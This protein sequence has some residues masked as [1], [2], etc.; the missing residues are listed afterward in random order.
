MKTTVGNF[1]LQ[2]DQRFPLDCEL[3][4]GLQNN[5]FLVSLIGNIA[6]DKAILYGCTPSGSK[7]DPGYVFLRTQD[8]PE[9]EVLYFEG[10]S[11][12]TGMYLKKEAQSV[13]AFGR[14]YP[15]AYTVRTLAAGLGDENY[16]WEDFTELATLPELLKKV[17]EQKQ[18]LEKME[19]APLGVVEI[20]AGKTIPG[21]YALCDGREL[22]QVDY[23]ELYAAIGTAFNA[24]PDYNGNTQTTSSDSFRLPDLRGRFLVGYS[25]SDT[26]Y[27][28]YGKASGQKTVVLTEEEM[29]SHT[30]TYTQYATG[31]LDRNRFSNKSNVDS[32]TPSSNTT[33]STGGKSG[34]TQAHENRP[35]YYT[36]AY[37]MRLTY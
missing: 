36:L 17:E 20:W 7:R 29:P 19:S 32:D 4:D 2:P 35:P 30:H 23:P 24:T 1:L 15:Q 12:G 25:S 9:G 33:G 18:I 10:G 5:I 3:L 28:S 14:E 6:G 34:V 37:I 13:V 31:S 21:G 27:N 8:Y 22:K 11:V 26:D 16:N